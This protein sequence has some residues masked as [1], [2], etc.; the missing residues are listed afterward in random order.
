VN[1]T[2]VSEN[3]VNTIFPRSIG[4]EIDLLLRTMEELPEDARKGIN[5]QLTSL[6]TE[7][8]TALMAVMD[9][10]GNQDAYFIVG[11]LYIWDMARVNIGGSKP[12]RMVSLNAVYKTPEGVSVVGLAEIGSYF[13]RRYVEEGGDEPA[14]IAMAKA[15]GVIR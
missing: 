8:R 14:S 12:E 15:L 1:G 7:K 6:I 4:A 2:D 13:I 3:D 9:Q 11:M 5:E 10:P